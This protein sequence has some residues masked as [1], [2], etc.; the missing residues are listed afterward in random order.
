MIPQV[1]SVTGTGTSKV[2]GFDIERNPFN[3]GIFC[4]VSGTV[5]YTIQHTADDIYANSY[6][7][8]TGIW[9]SNDNAALVGASSNQ[10]GNYAY[11]VRASRVLVNSGTGTVTVTYIQAGLLGG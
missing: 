5:N 1:V 11:P 6:N 2:V 8:S 3:I 9:F 10:D 7:P 4:T